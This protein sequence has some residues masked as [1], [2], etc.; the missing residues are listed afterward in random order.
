MTE[1]AP[2]LVADVLHACAAVAPQPWQAAEFIRS[3][4]EPLDELQYC[5]ESLCR[6]GVLKPV[7][8]GEKVDALV[9]TPRGLDLAR[10]PQALARFCEAE[11]LRFGVAD[12]PQRAAV[13]QTLLSPARPRVNR[14]LFWLNIA[15]FALGYVLALRQNVGRDFLLPIRQGGVVQD[16]VVLDILH[17]TG[18]VTRLD[19]LSGE[20][21]RLLTCGF[22]HFTILHL[23]MNMYALR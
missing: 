22:V 9:L 18:M 3:R 16:P 20:W 1:T 15:V 17:R 19:F 5:L 12:T 14:V 10:D 23:L 13:R 2:N 21:W 8:V 4:T 6:V 7:R 11:G